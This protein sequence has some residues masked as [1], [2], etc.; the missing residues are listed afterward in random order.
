M[1]DEA[2]CRSASTSAELGEVGGRA[3]IGGRRCFAATAPFA[4]TAAG[5]SV[6]T[7]CST[8]F[9]TFFILLLLLMLLLH[10]SQSLWTRYV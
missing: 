6:L 5:A 2:R 1:E 4:A 8:K 9:H 3:A 10:V 7:P